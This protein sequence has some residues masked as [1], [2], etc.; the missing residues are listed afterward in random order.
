MSHAVPPPSARP[1][2]Q[3][4]ELLA[5]LGRG[6]LPVPLTSFIGRERELIEAQVLLRQPAIRLLTVTGPGGVGKTRFALR[7]A[8]DAAPEFRGSVA[9]VTLAAVTDSSRVMSAIAEQFG[10]PDPSGR[11]S[12][13]LV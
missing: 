9:F 4:R 6:L 5:R 1:T 3:R 12:G 8:S 10:L 7:L 13:D 11:S 2:G